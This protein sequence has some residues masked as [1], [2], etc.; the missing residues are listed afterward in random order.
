MEAPK[1]STLRRQTQMGRPEHKGFLKIAREK[2]MKQQTLTAISME[3]EHFVKHVHRRS[4]ST[5]FSTE[6]SESPKSPQLWFIRKPQGDF[7]DL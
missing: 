3:T 6:D 5:N 1:R 4:H 2:L 7:G